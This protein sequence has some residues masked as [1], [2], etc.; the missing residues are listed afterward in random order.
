MAAIAVVPERIP[1]AEL[2]GIPINVQDLMERILD[3]TDFLGRM[4]AIQSQLSVD[5]LRNAIRRY[6]QY[7]LP[8]I[9]T[10]TEPVGSLAP[11]LDVHWIWHC[12]LLSPFDYEH[13]CV[14]ITGEVVDHVVI[15]RFAINSCRE[16]ARAIWES[17]YPEPFHLDL[18]NLH[19]VAFP[20]YQQ[21]SAYHLSAAAQRQRSFFYQVSLPHYQ[22]RSFLMNS[23]KR[24]RMFLA[25]KK[26]NPAAFLVPCYD[27]DLAWH[28]HQLHHR[29]YREDTVGYLGRMF[30]HDDTVTDRE[31]DSKLTQA[32]RITR[33]LW[34]KHFGTHF[35]T[36]GAMY[37]GDPPYG[38]LAPINGHRLA[39]LKLY[40]NAANAT[41][42]SL[43]TGQFVK[44]T[45][46]EN[47]SQLWGPVPMPRLPPG[48]AN[49]C[50]AAT[51]R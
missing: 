30:N 5:V 28:T 20:Q 37:R 27:I 26:R 31:P 33:E 23:V 18:T 9:K 8:L 36:C 12:H 4:N 19:N 3:E 35:A 51:H 13:D 44:C 6:E 15:S 45:T 47:V 24:Y 22:L 39:A 10:S 40:D 49:D 25:L 32:D 50:D 29:I 2:D 7:W 48:T 21:Q 34:K 46:P 1:D 41:F 42:L 43:V 11:P 16:K 38:S 14:R 17:K